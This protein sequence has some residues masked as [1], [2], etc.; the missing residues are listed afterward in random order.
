MVST[1]QAYCHLSHSTHAHVPV[2]H[3][4]EVDNN[5]CKA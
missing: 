3:M 4:D 5:K 1:K 2:S